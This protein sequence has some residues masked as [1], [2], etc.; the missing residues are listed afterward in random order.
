MN[1]RLEDLLHEFFQHVYYTAGKWMVP[2]EDGRDI[3]LCPE[4]Q[5]ILDDLEQALQDDPIS[6]D[7]AYDDERSALEG[8]DDWN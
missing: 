7:D 1:N 6:I 5:S 3:I 4:L 8:Y 2:D